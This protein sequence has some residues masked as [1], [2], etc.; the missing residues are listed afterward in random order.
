MK[1]AVSAFF[2]KLR[3]TQFL[4][5]F[6]QPLKKELLFKMILLYIELLLKCLIIPNNKKMKNVF[7]DWFIEQTVDTALENRNL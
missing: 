1:N 2:H 3:K 7:L 4:V 6:V 5:T